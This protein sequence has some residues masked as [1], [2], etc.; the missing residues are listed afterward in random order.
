[1]KTVK[2]IIQEQKETSIQ[3]F[4]SLVELGLLDESKVPLL[5]NALI[6]SPEMMTEAEKSVLTDIVESVILEKEASSKSLEKDMISTKDVPTVLT[7]RRKTIRVFPDSVRVAM[8][9]SPQLDKYISIPFGPKTAETGSRSLIPQLTEASYRTKPAPGIKP[10]GSGLKDAEDEDSRIARLHGDKAAKEHRARVE[11]SKDRDASASYHSTKKEHDGPSFRDAVRKAREHSSWEAKAGH[12][13]TSAA[14]HSTKAVGKA[15]VGGAKIAGRLAGKGLK[16]AISGI[17]KA[18]SA[19]IKSLVPKKVIDWAHKEADK[20]GFKPKKTINEAKKK[21]PSEE[22]IRAKKERDATNDKVDYHRMIRALRVSTDSKFSHRGKEISKKKHYRDI[23]K[24][25]ESRIKER[26]DEVPYVPREKKTLKPKPGRKPPPAIA[27]GF[28]DYLPGYKSS[29]EQMDQDIETAEKEGIKGSV[30][31]FVKRDVPKALMGV[32]PGA[33]MVGAASKVGAAVDKAK[34]FISQAAKKAAPVAAGAVGAIA[35][36]GGGGDSGSST[37]KKSYVSK[38]GEKKGSNKRNPSRVT[39]DASA[40]AQEAERNK[41]LFKESNFKKIKCLAESGGG[42]I[43]L[44]FG[45]DNISINSRLARKVV[46]VYES[47][48]SKNKKNMESMLDE[49]IGSYRKIINF[50]LRT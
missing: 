5:K 16:A 47:L 8:Y 12:I 2:Q 48:N 19:G 46:S 15:A 22:E 43:D 32:A 50:T 42:S 10:K 44:D 11:K 49:S 13:A 18:K 28:T 37:E 34:R 26:G 1:M 30:K 29:R 38:A 39:S 14:I 45:K 7:F 40:T 3:D 23:V 33:K 9:Y 25:L 20:A 36:S 41:K 24:N 4:M 31:K 17:R 21:E 6:V 27:E 35:A